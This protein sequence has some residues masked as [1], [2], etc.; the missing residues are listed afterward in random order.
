MDKKIG[1]KQLLFIWC[2]VEIVC[3]M[4]PVL[5]ADT[6][7]LDKVSKREEQLS[8]LSETKLEKTYKKQSTNCNK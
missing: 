3:V 6:S 4:I 5:K 1:A 7:C 8:T 2:N